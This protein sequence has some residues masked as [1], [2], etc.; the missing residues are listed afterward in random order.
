MTNSTYFSEDVK[1]ITDV[2]KHVLI[3]LMNFHAETHK[4]VSL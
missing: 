2:I 4:Y 1:K 3:L